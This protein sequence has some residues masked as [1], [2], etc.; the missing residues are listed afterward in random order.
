MKP[1]YIIGHKNPDIDSIAAAIAYQTYKQSTDK[2][3][4]LAATAGEISPEMSWLLNYLE[5]EHP[6]VLEDVGTKV[7]DLLDEVPPLSTGVNTTL[8]ELGQIMRQNKIKTM[9][10]VDAK[11][12]FLGLI[13]IGDIAMLFMDALGNGQEIEQSPEI[14]K[15]LLAKKTSQI[16]KTRDLILFEPQE[17]V[18]EAR[19][20]M[21]ASRFRN[22]PVVDDANRFLGMIS[23]YNLLQ[24]KRK[25]VILVDHNEKKQA[26]EGIEEAEIIEIIDH[27]RVGDLQTLWP[28]YFHNEPVG[29]TSTLVADM[30]LQN[31]IAMSEKLATLLLSGIMSDTM[32]FRSPTTTAK[33]H[34]VA[35]ELERISGLVA[36]AWGKKL[37]SEINRIDRQTDEELVSGDLKEYVSGETTF[38][39]S[40]VETV[41][42]AVFTARRAQLLQIMENMC[43]AKGYELMCLMVTNI[44]QDGTEMIIAGRKASLVEQAFQHEHMNGGIFLQ[45]V[46]S[47][48][49]QV[50]PVIYQ[51]LRQENLV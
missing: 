3:L 5:F 37:Y 26:V 30:F 24:M 13:T 33:D 27:H 1:T 50:V 46:L 32:I 36:L 39:I 22:Y 43:A 29:S 15:R 45:G 48:K 7:E 25:Q 17:R 20:N 28:I 10:V 19:K 18:D 9:P 4:Y 31:H 35:E 6:L 23:R 44:F 34:R 49:K 41:D 11:Q 40:Q 38:A 14:L 16:M 51:M 8:V 2:G 42:F 21:L 12:R 47:R